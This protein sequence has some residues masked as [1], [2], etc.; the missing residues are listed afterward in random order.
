MKTPN[1]ERSDYKPYGRA[2][3]PE[4]YADFL[5]AEDDGVLEDLGEGREPC[6]ACGG[7][8]TPYGAFGAQVV[9]DCLGCGERTTI[10]M[11]G[12]DGEEE[13]EDWEDEEYEHDQ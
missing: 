9:F 4:D 3:P 11:E 10:K 13:N 6:D 1:F 8:L 2:Y 12:W 5:A 7:Q